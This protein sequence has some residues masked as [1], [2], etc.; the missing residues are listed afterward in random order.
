VLADLFPDRAGLEAATA[1]YDGAVTVLVRGDSSWLG[2]T[3]DGREDGARSAQ[4]AAQDTER[5]HHL[6]AATLAGRGTGLVACGYA[7]RLLFLRPASR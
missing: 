6:A 5:L 4:V 7:G 2:M 3:L 1:G